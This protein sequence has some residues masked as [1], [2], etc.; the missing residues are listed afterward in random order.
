MRFSIIVPAFNEEAYL[1]STLDSIYASVEHLSARVD[2][3]VVDNNS[4]DETAAVAWAKGAT[5]VR[6]P[7]QGI[8]RARN[9]GGRHAKGDVLVFVDADAILPH[10]LLEAI[11]GAMSDPACV[12]GGVDVEYRPRRLL[13]KL[14]LRSWR[15]LG[16][17]MGMVQGATQFCHKD[18]SLVKTRLRQFP[19]N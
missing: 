16:N 1:A 5:V 13:V 17:L 11:L 12:G 19:A 6:E 15:L 4:E 18:D 2:V 8:S 7:V 9:T 10:T 14:Y 3:I